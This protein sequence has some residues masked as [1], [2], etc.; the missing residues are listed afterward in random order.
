MDKGARSI[1]ILDLRGKV[2][3][4]DLLVLCSGTSTKHVGTVAET[5]EQRLR[6]SGVRPATVEGASVG[7]WVL[8]D[9]GDVVVHVFLEEVR[10][11]YDI[12]GLW[13]DAPRIAVPEPEAAPPSR[14]VP[15][16]EARED[17]GAPEIAARTRGRRPGAS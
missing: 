9:Y 11:Y 5:I 6:R 10:T 8:L 1:Q 7:H 3:Y 2:D 17:L 12:E 16:S 14:R 4:A 15:A 13:M